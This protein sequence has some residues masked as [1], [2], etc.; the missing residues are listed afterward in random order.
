MQKKMVDEKK[1]FGDC[2]GWKSLAC[3]VV[4]KRRKNGYYGEKVNVKM[5]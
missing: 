1:Y 2:A 5:G 4:A 3:Q